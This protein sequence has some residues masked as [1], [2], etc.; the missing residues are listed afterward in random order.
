MQHACNTSKS[1][2]APYFEFNSVAPNIIS[3][4]F[5]LFY[6]YSMPKSMVSSSSVLFAHDSRP[7]FLIFKLVCP[8]NGLEK[9]KHHCFLL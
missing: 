8:G 1:V 5:F 4:I 3:K 2:L 7:H 6:R 9:E